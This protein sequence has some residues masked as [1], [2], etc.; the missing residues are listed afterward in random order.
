MATCT[1]SP[2]SPYIWWS[3]NV[4][5]VRTD[6]SATCSPAVGYIRVVG[7]LRG[8]NPGTAEWRCPTSGTGT[9]TSCPGYVT[10][11]Y[12]AGCWYAEASAYAPNWESYVRNPAY[13]S[14]V[15]L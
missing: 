8:P 9:I 10:R 14:C 2:G 7:G 12:S 5:Y 13:P 11:T 4:K 1:V 15:S 6:I 3:N